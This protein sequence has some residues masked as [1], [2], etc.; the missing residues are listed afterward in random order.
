MIHEDKPDLPTPEEALAHYGVLGMKWG[1]SR[2]KA[3][4]ASI[5]SARARTTRQK[6]NIDKQQDV[7]NNKKG[8]GEAV[9]RDVQK[10]SS[11]KTSYLKNPDRVI[12]ARMTR[13]EKVALG[14]VGLLAL[15]AAPI[16]V[17]AIAGTSAQSRRIER[18]QDLGKYD[19]KK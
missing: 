11:M 8:K 17:G 2:A 10:L 13:G 4:S 3:G 12:A 9:S 7:I 18:K 6:N 5:R 1:K 16:A 19:K 15:P 14:I